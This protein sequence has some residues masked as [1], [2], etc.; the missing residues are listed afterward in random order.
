MKILLLP[1]VILMAACVPEEKPAAVGLAN[2]ASVFCAEQGG[3]S[4]SRETAAGTVSDCHLP[5][6]S[7]VEEWDFY[8]KNHKG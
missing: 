2:P 8:R 6:G 1:L 7:V 4:V 5:D 3:K